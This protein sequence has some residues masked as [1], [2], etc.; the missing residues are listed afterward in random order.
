MTET[1][2][3]TEA[4]PVVS[5]H[6]ANTVTGEYDV[7]QPLPYPFHLDADGNVTRQDFWRG[8][9]LKLLGFQSDPDVHEVDLLVEDW[10]PTAAAGYAA[11]SGACSPVDA[12]GMWP[13][14]RDADGTIWSHRFP[15]D[16]VSRIE[17]VSL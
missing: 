7:R 3:T 4:A 6:I 10:L 14:F 15:V 8:E 16:Q 13:V 9:P 11:A 2:N 5:L 1:S 12:V 17:A